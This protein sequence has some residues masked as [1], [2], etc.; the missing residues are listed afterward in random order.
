MQE[1]CQTAALASNVPART[2]CKNRASGKAAFPTSPHPPAPWP[3]AL[4]PGSPPPTTSPAPPARGWGSGAGKRGTPPPH[5]LPSP[6]RRRRTGHRHAPATTA[7]TARARGDPTPGLPATSPH[8]P[9]VPG[10]T[11][12]PTPHHPGARRRVIHRCGRLAAA[13]GA[14]Q[15][16][17]RRRQPAGDPPPP[18]DNPAFRSRRPLPETTTTTARPR[19]CPP[20]ATTIN[21]EDQKWTKRQDERR[22]AGKPGGTDQAPD[23]S[24][25][26]SAFRC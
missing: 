17:R 16:G 21:G 8:P 15:P 12:P 6:P 10:A 22:L 4:R 5:A 11:A 13:P 23:Y 19:P 24:C 1:S 18:V 2:P 7:R 26:S 20:Q 3:R 9:P 14:G 25:A